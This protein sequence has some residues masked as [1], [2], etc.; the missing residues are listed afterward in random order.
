MTRISLLVLSLL[1][2]PFS[3]PVAPLLAQELEPAEKVKFETCD[4]VKIQGKFYKSPMKAAPAVIMVHNIE[5]NSNKENW[6]NL[7]KTLRPYFS[8]LTFDLRGHGDSTEIDPKVY[9]LYL[10][11][12][13][14]TRGA[15]VN[16]TKLDWKD[17]DKSSYTVLSTTLPPFIVP[18]VQERAR[19]CNAEHRIG[20]EQG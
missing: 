17:I 13:K 16:K 10:N 15:G 18:S 12:V 20:R 8:V 14:I 3:L 11:N 7:A 5:E 2:L 6:T 1:S 19:E 9:F 4:G